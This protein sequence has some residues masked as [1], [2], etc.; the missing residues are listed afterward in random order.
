MTAFAGRSDPSALPWRHGGACVIVR[1]R[2]TP[3]SSK[4]AVDGVEDTVE[5]PALKARVRAVPAEGEAN[6]AL[7]KLLAGWLGVSQGSVRLVKG[8]KSRVK[9]VEIAGDAKEIEARLAGRLAE[10]E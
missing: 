3:K 4:D 10:L 9:S 1:V 7:I 8:G 6:A 5:G 2:I